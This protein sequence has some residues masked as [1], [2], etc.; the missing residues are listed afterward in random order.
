MCNKLWLYRISYPL[1]LS[2]LFQR[3]CVLHRLNLLSR[4]FR[5]VLLPCRA[6]VVILHVVSEVNVSYSG[7]GIKPKPLACDNL[8]SL[9]VLL[10]WS[11]SPVWGRSTFTDMQ[12]LLGFMVTVR[13]FLSRLCLLS[14]S[15]SN[16]LMCMHW[17]TEEGLVSAEKTEQMYWGEICADLSKIW[18]FISRLC[19]H[20]RC[21]DS[22]FWDLE[23]QYVDTATAVSNLILSSTYV[24]MELVSNEMCVELGI[25]WQW[26]CR[27]RF[28]NMNKQ[29]AHLWLI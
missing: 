18:S 7:T 6:S 4:V 20:F 9:Y 22:D 17:A 10:S 25:K 11:L 14:A 16:T 28:R 3:T 15:V 26:W 29:A 24:K 12:L 19:G 2:H 13:S 1:K 27:G 21:C 5:A 23:T 8:Q